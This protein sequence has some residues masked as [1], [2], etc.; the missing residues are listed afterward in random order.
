MEDFP[1]RHVWL[2]EGNP[3]SPTTWF[4]NPSSTALSRIKLR[5]AGDVR[6]LSYHKP[7]KKS[8]KSSLLVQAPT[9]FPSGVDSP[10]KS[11]IFVGLIPIFRSSHGKLIFDPPSQETEEWLE[12]LEAVLSTHGGV[13]SSSGNLGEKICG[14]WILIGYNETLYIYTW[15]I[16]LEN[17]W[18]GRTYR[19]VHGIS[20]QYQ[21]NMHW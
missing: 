21:R 13:A 18:M 12:S 4:I 19:D 5:S 16:N 9:M 1:A 15:D 17:L 20:I 2:L 7:T 14:M 10:V 8:I 6:Q 3:K 11:P